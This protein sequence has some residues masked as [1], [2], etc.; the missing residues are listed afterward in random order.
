MLDKT[1]RVP[2]YFQ[3][4]KLIRE[5]ITSGKYKPGEKL[6]SENQ[7]SDFYNVSRVTI[8]QALKLLQENSTIYPVH[9]VGTFVSPLIMKGM[10]GFLGFTEKTGLLDLE[11]TSRVLAFQEVEQLPEEMQRQFQL[12]DKDTPNP[13]SRLMQLKRTRLI[14]GVPAAIEDVYLP[15]EIFSGIEKYDFSNQSLYETLNN[16]WGI[17]PVFSMQVMTAK[18]ASQEEAD[19]LEIPVGK[20]LLSVFRLNLSEDFRVIEY[21]ESVYNTDKYIFLVRDTR[22]I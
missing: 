11:V 16:V 22:E 10:S 20:P 6:P 8:R 15:L 12:L 3:I 19:Q 13:G 21:C 18:A 4:A 2:R 5:E 17:V 14:D 9:G 7:L 1:S